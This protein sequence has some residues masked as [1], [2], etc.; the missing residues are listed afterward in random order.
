MMHTVVVPSAYFVQAKIEDNFSELQDMFFTRSKKIVTTRSTEI[1]ICNTQNGK[2][3]DLFQAQSSDAMTCFN[4]NES[5]LFSVDRNGKRA[6][7]DALN[8][9]I[10]WHRK[11]IEELDGRIS[12]NDDYSRFIIQ[13]LN[14][15]VV[16]DAES[17][18]LQATLWD[19]HKKGYNY[20]TM[21]EFLPGSSDIIVFHNGWLDGATQ[22][23]VVYKDIIPADSPC[24]M[25]SS[26]K[27]RL[28]YFSPCSKSTALVRNDLFYTRS[29]SADNTVGDCMENPLEKDDA[30]LH[31]HVLNSDSGQSY[32]FYIQDR[33]KPAAALVSLHNNGETL[34]C[35]TSSP[36]TRGDFKEHYCFV[37]LFDLEE[38]SAE[39]TLTIACDS[40]PNYTHFVSQ[41]NLL[42]LALRKACQ[43]WDT[44]S[45]MLL[46][47]LDISSWLKAI[48]ISPHGDQIALANDESITI[49]QKK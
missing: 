39:R 37:D 5:R 20:S 47:S 31:A 12:F 38:N 36:D 42:L 18:A 17:G 40:E 7:W 23:G 34:L 43:L 28:V 29:D 25:F 2:E 16:I 45:K 21:A 30:Y 6:C 49:Y 27:N 26:A 19:D 15:A 24:A 10:R 3:L 46:W 8:K 13:G 9:S 48:S 41:K 35:I 32:D 14:K 11:A 1:N 44:K 22:P 33:C 4:R